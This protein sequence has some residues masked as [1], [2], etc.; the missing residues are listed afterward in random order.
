MLIVVI[1]NKNEIMKNGGFEMIKSLTLIFNRIIKEKKIPE[2][3]ENM[4]IKSIYKNKGARDEIKNRRGIFLTST[5]SKLFEKVLLQKVQ[6]KIRRNQF[7]MGGQ[8]GRSATDNWMMIM[9]ILDNNRRLNR[10]TYVVMADAEKCFDKLWLKDC[11]IDMNEA[12]LRERE[13]ELLYILNKKAKITIQTPVGETKE[14]VVNEIVKQGTVFGPQLCCVNSA[15]INEIGENSV[16]MI[17]PTIGNK[18]PVY[19]DDILGIGSREAVEKVGRNLGEMEKKKKYT[20][21]VGNG[22]SHYMVIKTGREKEKEVNIVLEKG[23]I[24]KTEDYKYLGNWINEKGTVRVY[25]KCP[26][27]LEE[28]GFIN[29]IIFYK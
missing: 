16:T 15:K 24:E 5:V 21:N 6:S 14:I 22:K 3:W 25:S 26:F 19:V 2:Q 11:L 18:S 9:G 28:R 27:K 4:K 1:K 20:F 17:S 8:R 29:G 7:Q 23:K 12:G 13:V 10:N